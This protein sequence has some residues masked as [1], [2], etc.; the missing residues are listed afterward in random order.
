MAYLPSCLVV[1]DAQKDNVVEVI[2]A[3][4]GEQYGFSRQLI[5]ADT[6]N[7]SPA[8]TTTAWLAFDASTN[9]DQVAVMLRFANG[10][11]PPLADPEAAW[12][13]NG[14]ISASDAMTAINGTNLK[15]AAVSG[16]VVPWDFAVAFCDSL[17]LMFKPEPEI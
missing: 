13:E 9:E 2:T 17:G 8:S 10:D 11:L 5:P 6:V 7:P 1:T 14:L 16:D 15:V 12:G 3:Y 4:R